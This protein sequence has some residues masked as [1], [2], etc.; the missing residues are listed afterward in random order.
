MG[1]LFGWDS[2]KDLIQHLE[3]NGFYSPGYKLLRNSLVGNNHWSLLERPDGTVTISLELI[4]VSEGKWGYKDLCEDMGPTHVNCPI[5][6]INLASPS[7]SKYAKEW[8]ERVH[9]YHE[10]KR[11]RPKY[12]NGQIWNIYGK[13]YRLDKKAEKRKGWVGTLI[14]TGQLFRIPFRHLASGEL[15]S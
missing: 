4:S 13:E 14:E 15:I 11:N 6:F 8:R 5:T 7:Q 9:S 10:H 2:K 1:W 3:T 12:A